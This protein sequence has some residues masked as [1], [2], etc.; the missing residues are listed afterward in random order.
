M[1]VPMELQMN[2]NLGRKVLLTYVLH[3]VLRTIDVQIIF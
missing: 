3:D 2:K 1:T